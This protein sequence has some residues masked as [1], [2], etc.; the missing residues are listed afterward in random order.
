MI[1]EKDDNT[2]VADSRT[3]GFFHTGNGMKKPAVR[4]AA[5]SLLLN[6]PSDGDRY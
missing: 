6:Y 2:E 5:T 4:E 1:L 3:A